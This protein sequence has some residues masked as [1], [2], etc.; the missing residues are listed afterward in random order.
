[1]ASEKGDERKN[2]IFG[3]Y[4]HMVKRQ[5]DREYMQWF[6]TKC[7]KDSA[8]A[9]EQEENYV[10]PKKYHRYKDIIRD[11]IGEIKKLD[12]FLFKGTEKLL[13]KKKGDPTKSK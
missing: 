3:M 11:Y 12:E 13:P 10:F 4:F 2:S 6:V 9:L 5:G 1:M 7:D 8:I